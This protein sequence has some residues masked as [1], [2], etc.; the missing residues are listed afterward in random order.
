MTESEAKEIVARRP[1][2]YHRFEIFP[3]VMTPG[4]YDPSGTLSMLDLPVDMH[5]MRVLEIGP[6]DGYFT[7]ELTARGAEV[8]A[9]DYAMR[10]FYG[11]GD[12]ER[13]SGRQFQFH[14][15]NIFEIARLGLQP[16]DVVLCLGVLYHLPD[17]CRALWSIRPL[18]GRQL[19]LETLVSR[20]HDDEPFAEYLPASSCN[21]DDTNFWAPNP[22]CCKLMLG[23]AAYNVD[24]EW[25]ND[26]RAMFHCRPDAN[27]LASTKMRTA[28]SF[29][30]APPTARERVMSLVRRALG[31]PR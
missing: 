5:G 22:L 14:N 26:T 2:W 30:G 15:V 24:R 16:F 4:V 28:Y 6:A 9:V 29:M 27:P 25:L 21:N 1:F 17:P 18:V 20:K 10:D 3:G 8:T 11:F 12:M 31:R 13:C 19:I 23:D 7:K